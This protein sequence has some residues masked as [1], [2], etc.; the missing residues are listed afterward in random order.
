MAY[1]FSTAMLAGLVCD[2]F[3]TAVVEETRFCCSRLRDSGVNIIRKRVIA[4]REQELVPW[5]YVGWP[6][7]SVVRCTAISSL[8]Q[9]PPG[10]RRPAGNHTN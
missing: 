5:P 1:R 10:E 8:R 2:G 7:Y 3:V 4:D 9:L 6:T